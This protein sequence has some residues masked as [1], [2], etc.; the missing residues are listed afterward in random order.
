MYSKKQTPDEESYARFLA[1]FG[2]AMIHGP[3]VTVK[4]D[5]LQHY[6]STRAELCELIL[7][8]DQTDFVMV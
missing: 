1:E 6:R 4:Q 3:R 5:P 7:H 8:S 2:R